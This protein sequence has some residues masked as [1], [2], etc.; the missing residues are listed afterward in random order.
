MKVPA[1]SIGKWIVIAVMA[2]V[3]GLAVMPLR[4]A[5]GLLAGNG[6]GTSAKNVT[7]NIWAGTIRDLRMGGALLGDMQVQLKP[8]SLLLLS[9]EFRV[10]RIVNKGAPGLSGYVGGLSGSIAIR[11]LTGELPIE[12]NDNALPISHLELDKFS[13]S[14]RASGCK[15]ASGSVRLMLHRGAIPGANLDSGL[16]GQA[17]CDGADLLLP[18]VSQ[19]ALERAEIRIKYSGDYTVS[20]IITQPTI[21]AA[22]LLSAAGFTPISGGFRKEIKGRL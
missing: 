14:M 10:N 13:V 5:I 15:L 3:I 7:G 16:L 11:Q 1:L 21:E 8:M 12:T 6:G 2:I 9:P 19:S 20:L 18:L 22:P 4:S 17:R